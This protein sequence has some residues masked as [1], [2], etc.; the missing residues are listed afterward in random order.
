MTTFP[1]DTELDERVARGIARLEPVF[2]GWLR[3]I[4]RDELDL[5]YTNLCVAGQLSGHR[6]TPDDRY[7]LTMDQLG[8][9]TGDGAIS[10]GFCLSWREIDARHL[11][12]GTDDDPTET[13]AP[14]T[15]AWLRAINARLKA[16]TP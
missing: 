16:P 3:T 9:G 12:L 15:A 10:H 8:L 1:T 7:L 14:L 6:G 13:Y 4:N 11:E 5:A 2:P